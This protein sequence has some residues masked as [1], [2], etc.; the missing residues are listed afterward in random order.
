MWLRFDNS[1][2]ATYVNEIRISWL[3]NGQIAELE[4]A[5]SNSTKE[6]IKR[7]YVLLLHNLPIS[8]SFLVWSHKP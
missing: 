4:I 2:N 8:W 5:L 3:N 6:K 7:V 1:D